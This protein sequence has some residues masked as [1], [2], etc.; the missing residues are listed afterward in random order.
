[1]ITILSTS[2]LHRDG[3]HLYAVQVSNETESTET[4]KA[5]L[6]NAPC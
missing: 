6:I 1:M 5:Q 4:L 2:G 3:S